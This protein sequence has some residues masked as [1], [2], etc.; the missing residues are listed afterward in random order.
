MKPHTAKLLALH[1]CRPG[2][3]FAEQ[4]DLW[5]EC[6]D[7]IPRGDW[8]LWLL[9]KQAG[10]VDS[11]SRKKLVGVLAEIVELVLP[12]FERQY[13][14][15][16]RVRACIETLKA[17][18]IGAATLDDVKNATL[19]WDAYDADSMTAYGNVAHAA[20]SAVSYAAGWATA[21]DSAWAAACA[22]AYD[23]ADWV[24]AYS[25]DCNAARNEMRKKCADIVRKHYPKAPELL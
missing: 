20:Y 18:S 17:Y 9:G 2:L 6:W 23:G 16:S 10:P 24:A 21:Y 15:D 8:S 13:P 14:D 12:I 19:P 7:N 3:D 25:F 22:A 11:P 4:F 1:A 5:Q